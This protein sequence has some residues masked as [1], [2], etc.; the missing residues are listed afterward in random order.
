M[1]LKIKSLLTVASL[2]CAVAAF[3]QTL[4]YDIVLLGKTVGQTTVSKKQSGATI[5]Y[6]LTSHTDARIL[7]VGKKDDMSTSALFSS[8]GHMV[9]SSYDDVKNGEHHFTKTAAQGSKI[10]V[11]KDGTK[12]SVPGP[13]DFCSLSLYFTEPKDHQN[14]FAER[15]GQFYEIVKDGDHKYKA[16]FEGYTAV[17]TYRS[18]KLVELQM[19]EALGEVVM[20]LMQ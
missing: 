11:N 20:K 10:A 18:G 4:K 7:S 9:S 17:Y 14:F 1:M 15:M 8:S 16:S 12:S 3:P 6:T 2:L 5:R 19:K 13:V